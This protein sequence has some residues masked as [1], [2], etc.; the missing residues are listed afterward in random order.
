MQYKKFLIAV[1]ILISFCSCSFAADNEDIYVRKDLFESYM[2]NIDSKLDSIIKEQALMREDIKN[3]TQ[4]IGDVN[5][6]ITKVETCID[7]LEKR[8][9]DLRDDTKG[10][11]GDLNSS[12][13][14]WSVILGLVAGL[15]FF[16]ILYEEYEAKRQAQRQS[17]T[18]EDVEKLVERLLEAKMKGNLNN[19][20]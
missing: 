20:V 19:A 7:G 4:A 12:I 8:V 10:R 13:Y 11:I 1:L 14:L 3:L 9:D 6:R 5:T 2:K 18:L 15:P 17:F 16:K